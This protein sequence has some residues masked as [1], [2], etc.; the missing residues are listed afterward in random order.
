L[1][2]TDEFRITIRDDMTGSVQ[3]NSHTG[4][5]QNS[6]EVEHGS[7]I[8]FACENVR[9]RALGCR[10]GNAGRLSK[11]VG[12]EGAVTDRDLI[13]QLADAAQRR[14]CTRGQV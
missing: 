3:P 8:V 7:R 2:V 12:I 5:R 4:V 6:S 9:D 1:K 13:A 10:Q 11:T 14:R